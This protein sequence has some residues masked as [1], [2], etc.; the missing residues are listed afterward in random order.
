MLRPVSSYV[1][2]DRNFAM[3]NF[4]NSYRGT[5]DHVPFLGR[6]GEIRSMFETNARL[7]N[8]VRELI[9][10]FRKAFLISLTLDR[11]I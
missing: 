10:H 8:H 2:Y 6:K 5:D 3:A 1:V 7:I 4:S 9:S 11:L